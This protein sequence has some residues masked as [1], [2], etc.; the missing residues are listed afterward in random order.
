[1]GKFYKLVEQYTYFYKKKVLHKILKCLIWTF[2]SEI[3]EF[4]TAKNVNIKIILTKT[5]KKLI[6]AVFFVFFGSYLT[7]YQ[8]HS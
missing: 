8:K 1:M 6:F 2:W 4:F 5:A 7:M 3:F